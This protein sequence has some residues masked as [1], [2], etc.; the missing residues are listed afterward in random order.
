MNTPAS[1]A[2]FLVCQRVQAAE[3]DGEINAYFGYDLWST[4]VHVIYRTRTPFK[5]GMRYFFSVRD[6]SLL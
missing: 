6:E 3:V 5:V 2:T 1:Y 4:V